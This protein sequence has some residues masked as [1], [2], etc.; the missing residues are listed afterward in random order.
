MKNKGFTLIE[1][2]VVI[3]LLGLIVTLFIP[4]VI[5]ILQQ[6]NI[7]IY[8][9]KENE[10]IEA[11]NDYIDYDS[12]FTFD[13]NEKYITMNTLVSKNYMS[14]IIDTQSGNE[15]KAFAKV[16]KNAVNG[17]DVEACLICDEYVTDNSFCSSDAYNDL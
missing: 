17:Y 1:L 12:D 15:C 7:K 11:C 4:N 13:G 3:I 9:V 14:K 16:T 2:L 10:L 8:K 6:N 5:K